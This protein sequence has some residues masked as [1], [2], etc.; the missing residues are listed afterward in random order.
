MSKSRAR[1]RTPRLAALIV[2]GAL[3]VLA[4][5][6]GQALAGRLVATGHDADFHC[7]TGTDVN[8]PQC[9][10]IA[11]A[12]GAVRAGAPNPT[13]PV[14]V[15]D[16]GGL[17]MQKAIDNAFGAGTVPMKVVDPRSDEFKAL[18]INVATYSAVAV[19]SDSTCGGCDL[20]EFDATPDSDAINARKADFESFFNAGGGIFAAAGARHGDGDASTGADNYYSFLPL[21]V[22]GVAVAAPFTL[23]DIGKSLGLED[24]K[25]SPAI[26]THDDINCCPTHNS[27]KIPAGGS[28]LQVAEKDSKGSAETLIAKG[29]ISGG[30]IKGDTPPPPTKV[31]A[32]A[33]L[34]STKKCL[35]RRSF[36]I[37]LR[38]PKGYK[39]VGAT[40]KV[41]G[42][43]VATRKKGKRVRAPVNLRNLP[44]GSYKVSITVLLDSGAIVK[45]TRKYKTC[46]KKQKHR[47][48]SP[49]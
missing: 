26:G 11:V 20:N 7:S 13:L 42:R 1:R 25:A 23:T 38:N 44:K 9:H 16:R 3:S 24:S 33:T 19:A 32:V 41:N 47:N 27:F 45:G 15:L 37:R 10:Y 30:T 22:G 18:P 48:K 8:G 34:P 49:V 43:T 4:L 17:E 29:T 2:F 21:T 28:A 12:I 5:I 36:R 6:P 40:V 14:L 39:I 35:S 46:T 31:T